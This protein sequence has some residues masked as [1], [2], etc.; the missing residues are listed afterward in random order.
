MTHE[1]ETRYCLVLPCLSRTCLYYRLDQYFDKLL[2]SQ[3][4]PSWQPALFT[5]VIV[6]MSVAPVQQQST[7]QRPRERAPPQCN[8]KR[9]EYHRN[10][11]WAFCDACDTKKNEGEFLCVAGPRKEDFE[12]EGSTR[13][14]YSL[15]PA[16]TRKLAWEK[17]EFD[18]TWWCVKCYAKKWDATPEDVR[19][20]LGWVKWRD[21]RQKYNTI[22]SYKEGR[23]KC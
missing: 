16:F 17:G 18:A 11:R 14:N 8:D 19:Q 23:V 7:Y 1:A 6:P 9:F 22:R 2:C 20:M 13:V 15:P 4:S 3:C 5:P 12:H 10:Q 21:S